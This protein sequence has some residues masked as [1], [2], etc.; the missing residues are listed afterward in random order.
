M[1]HHPLVS[2]PVIT[3]N[4]ASYIIDGLESIKAQSYENIEL[5]ISDDCSTDNTFDICKKW[6]EKNRNYFIRAEIIKTPYNMGVSGNLNNAIKECHGEWIKTLSGDDIFFP[7]TIQEYVDF[8]SSHPECNIAFAKF[9]FFGDDKKIV[10][11]AEKLYE[12]DFY[13]LIKASYK[14]QYK[15]NLKRLFLPGPGLIYRKALWEK[16]GGFDEKYPFCEE[17]PFTTKLLDLKEHIYFIDKKLYGY[18]IRGDSLSRSKSK[19]SLI[20]E[21]NIRDYFRRVKRKK[22][23]KAGMLLTALDTT[24]SYGLDDATISDSKGKYIWFSLLRFISPLRYK[25][26]LK[27]IIGM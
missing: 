1:Y 15:Q 14:V 11:E 27:R 21:A 8:V 7:Y 13:P 3:Y 9:H 24:I 20:T 16:I 10:E 22:M 5:I 19:V 26:M 23:L 25:K 6:I 12:T 17:V 18:Q 2:I 4:S